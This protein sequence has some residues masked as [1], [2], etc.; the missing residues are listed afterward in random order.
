MGKVLDAWNTKTGEIG[1]WIGKGQTIWNK[2]GLVSYDT[3]N[4][5]TCGYHSP[6][7]D[8]SYNHSKIIC[9]T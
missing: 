3:C 1:T 2:V 5:V 6:T 7:L 8:R 9:G 4:R